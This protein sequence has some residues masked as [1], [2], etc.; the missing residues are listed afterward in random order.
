MLAEA[1]FAAC[2]LG[3][4]IEESDLVLMLDTLAQYEAKADA[5]NAGALPCWV[6]HLASVGCRGATSLVFLAR[7]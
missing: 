2:V 4:G 5:S 6:V 7:W 3:T 1:L